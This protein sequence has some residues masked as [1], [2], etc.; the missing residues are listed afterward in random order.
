M[1]KI[2]I[3]YASMT[4]N[5]EVMAEILEQSLLEEG[6][7]VTVKEALRAKPKEM[8]K[9]DGIL[10]GAYTYEGGEI[11]DEFMLFYE[12][13]DQIDLTGKLMAVFGSGDTFY[14]DTYCVAVDIIIEK[15]IELGANVV[16]EGL[17]VDLIPE[18]EDEERCLKFGKD[19][20]EKVKEL[21][22]S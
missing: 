19:F 12:E 13:M 11:G 4:G 1:K 15:L 7:E 17:K 2:L 9:Y 6:L 21:M 8:L 18:G 16:L 20:A 10:L 5:T 3:I 22:P 14:Q